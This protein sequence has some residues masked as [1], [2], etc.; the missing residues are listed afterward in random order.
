MMNQTL[1]EY[2]RTIQSEL[3]TATDTLRA[4][5]NG[6]HVHHTSSQARAKT[7]SLIQDRAG[8]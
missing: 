4:D 2:L 6:L 3:W 8:P 5:D 7:C 1:L